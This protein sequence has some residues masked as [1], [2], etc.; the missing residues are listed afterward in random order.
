VKDGGKAAAGP[1]AE[2]V[3]AATLAETEK[4]VERVLS[5][6]GPEDPADLRDELRENMFE[7]I[8]LFRDE[9][10][11]ARGLDKVRELRERYPRIGIKNRG[12]RYNLDWCRNLE[13][14]GMILVAEAI[15]AGALA[16]KE[17]RGSHFRT[18]CTERDDKN[19]LKHTIARLTADGPKLE[20]RPVTITK[21]EPKAR[22][23]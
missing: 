17:S 21:W 5:A 4:K 6:D 8:G 10:T 11:M 7:T 23:Y 18:D 3:V 14:E 20:Y 9:E 16:R 2:K 1:Q 12:R 15:A 19:F 22:T 13:L